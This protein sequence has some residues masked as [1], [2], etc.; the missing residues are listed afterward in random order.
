MPLPASTRLGPY[1]IVAP[2]G[3]GGM[4]EV[5]RARDAR[6]DRDVAV[7]VLP[8]SVSSDPERLGRFERE[9]RAAAALSHPNVLAVFDFGVHAGSPYLVTELL[10]GE[11]LRERL[12]EG[13]LPQRKTVDY[14]LQVAKGMAAAHDKGILHRDLKPDNVFITA[15]GRIKILDFGLAKVTHAHAAAAAADSTVSVSTRPG[16]VMGTAGYISPEQV[17]GEEADARSDIFAFGCIL[18][19]M[20]SGRRAFHSE[21]VVETLHAT[22]RDEPPELT[23]P[24]G[25]VSPALERIVRHCLEKNPAERFQSAHDLAFA[26]E[27]ATAVTESAAAALV[28]SR[29]PR[30]FRV[31]GT[32]AALLAL[33]F[34]G[35]FLAAK[36]GARPQQPAFHRLTYRRGTIRGARFTPDGQNIVYGAAWEGRRW[37]IFSTRVDSSDSRPLGIEDAQVLG[38]SSR[39]ELA[40]LGHPRRVATVLWNER[41][42]LATVPLA[43]GA[44]R[45]IA[46]GISFADWSPDGADLAV[47]RNRI[48]GRISELEFPRGKVIYRG[49]KREFLDVRVSRKGDLL[50]FFDSS[51]ADDYAHVAIMDRA[52][53]K[54]AQSRAFTN[55]TGLAWSADGREVWFTAASA[56]GT[57]ALY[58]VDLAGRERLLLRVPAWLALKDVSRDGRVL[59]CKDTANWG[60]MV[61]APGQPE[62]RDVS[63]YSW[64]ILDDMSPDGRSIVFSEGGEAGEDRWGIYMRD[65]TGSPAVRLGDG[66]FARLSPDGKWVL[67]LAQYEEGSPGHLMLLPTGPGDV[68]SLA[69]NLTEFARYSYGWLPDSRAIFYSMAR[70]DGV[71]RTYLLPLLGGKP[72]QIGGDGVMGS[73]VTP[74]GTQLLA[75][76]PQGWLLCPIEGGAPRRIPD[77]DASWTP[78]GWHTD[79]KRLRVAEPGSDPLNIVLVDP[80]TGLKEPWKQL[81]RS[82][83]RDRAGLI[84]MMLPRFSRD[85]NSYAYTYSRQ[86]SDLYVVDG[87]K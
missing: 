44:P 35:G 81:A 9:A 57:R 78:L 62:E 75:R 86:L 77:L 84:G 12:A 73:L 53:K 85:G 33:V 25:P 87:I 48:P 24:G 32:A 61:S 69:E 43:G 51:D 11:S 16:V 72:R 54:R 40:V 63:W 56:G 80:G 47:V 26:L 20:I 13:P 68:R 36:R 23:R 2:L 64:S 50:A 3:A 58:A 34:T 55:I 17:R 4:G 41:G 76:D 10:E 7:K 37:E 79:D 70:E 5:Y 60:M 28:R 74:D 82:A 38:V 67:A 22:L 19:E 21:N 30:R 71:I 6:L 52:G 66:V 1:E 49:V 46:E 29:F 15:D 45:E 65:T 59:L 8:P 83:A 18:Y 14:A 31:A 42:T 39:G 27:S